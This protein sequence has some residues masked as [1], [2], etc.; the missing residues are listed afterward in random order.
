MSPSPIRIGNRAVGADCPVYVIA[1]I[2]SNHNQDKALA[3]DM[4]DMA[5]DAGADAVKFQSILFDELYI[6]KQEDAAFRDWF[7]QIE[8][9]ED[10]YPDLASRA[11]AAGVDFLS[12][13]T[14][15]RAVDLL[16]S[17]EVPAYKLASPQVQGNLAVVRKAA[18]TGKPLIMSTGYCLYPD[19]DRAIA[20]CTEEGNE[21]IVALHC[22]S[23]YPA[24]P[25]EANLRFMNTLSD[26]TGRNVGYSDHSIGPH[27]AVAAVA[28]GACV[29]EKHVTTDRAQPGPDHH[30]AMTFGEFG[31]M[32]S[33][34]RDVSAA[35]G[36]GRR[37]TLLPDEMKHRA[38]VEL[39]A[40]ASRDFAAGETFDPG[41]VVAYRSQKTGLP[42]EEIAAFAGRTLREPVAEGTLL[43]RD[44]FGTGASA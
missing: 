29:I 23:K 1:E 40:F 38:F 32:V 30:F 39:K 3:L 4:I 14:Y 37:E 34:I 12:A 13:P 35:L 17:C 16:E 20:V 28:R 25:A 9:D 18:R 10:W 11:R 43:T 5:A 19:I 33:M 31:D 42:M 27:L 22:I 24:E 36:T 44:M 2:G 6:E 26:M 8:L 41:A 15:E 7:R 21:D